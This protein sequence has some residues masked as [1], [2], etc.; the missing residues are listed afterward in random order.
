MG[1]TARSDLTAQARIRLAA[2]EA[3]AERGFAATS[4]RD[5]AQAAGVSPG[6][7]QHY[8][9]TKADL[10][11]AV[12]QYV[13]DVAADAFA[14]VTDSKSAAELTEEFGQ[15]ITALVRDH[16]AALR[17]AARAIAD[18]DEGGIELFDSLVALATATYGRHSADGY[19]D[20]DVD[21]TWA[22]L[23][24]VIYNLGTLLLQ[25]AIDRHLPRSFSDDAE[26]ERWRSASTVLFRKG[27]YRA[28][29]T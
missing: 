24:I 18:G 6:L 27:H 25:P 5:V 7:V 8:F 1:A 9:R 21:L 13:I 19:L 14:D 10:R 23:Q 29:G 3:F 4:V 22:P 20:P 26:L 16:V 2:L 15:R 12:H 28:D 17:Y 11:V